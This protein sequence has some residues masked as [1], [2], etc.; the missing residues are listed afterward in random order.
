MNWS[1]RCGF[2]NPSTSSNGWENGVVTL[3]TCPLSSCHRWNI[4]PGSGASSVGIGKSTKISSWTGRREKDVQTVGMRI[5]LPADSPKLL[6]ILDIVT[7]FPKLFEIAKAH[8]ST[9]TIKKQTVPRFSC[10]RSFH[11]DSSPS[12]S[13]R[14]DHECHPSM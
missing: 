12:D 8:S 5:S 4:A 14:V 13:I 3:T 2:L 6:L 7:K 9:I 10:V 11:V 1:C